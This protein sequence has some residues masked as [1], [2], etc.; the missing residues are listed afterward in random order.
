MGES[1]INVIE[2]EVEKL[3]AETKTLIKEFLQLFSR[4]GK[5]KYH[6]IKT[7]MKDDA[8]ISQQNGRRIPIQ[9][10]EVVDA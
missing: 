2:E 5:I 7:K 4:T 10:Q 8:A 9:M 6:K 3:I 1:V